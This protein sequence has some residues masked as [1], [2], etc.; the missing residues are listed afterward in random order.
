MDDAIRALI[1][2]HKQEVLREAFGADRG[3]I[4]PFTE[5]DRGEDQ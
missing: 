2:K 4:K 1:K 3:R 5:H